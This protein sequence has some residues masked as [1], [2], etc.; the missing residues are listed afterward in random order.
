MGS[1]KDQIAR[2]LKA[3]IKDQDRRRMCTLRLVTA[4][5]NDRNI[6]ARSNGK[7]CVSDDDVQQILAKMVKQRE[8]SERAFEA[9]GRL[10]LAQQ[11]REEI[12]IIRDFL[13]RQLGEEE[14]L[15]AIDEAVSSIGANCLKDMGRTMSVL[16]ERYPGQMDFAMASKVVKQKLAGQM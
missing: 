4:A 10:E 5:I 6:T 16:K 8:E 11:E 14:V 3:A 12:E 15:S 1:L 2:E 7:D 13:P 9:A